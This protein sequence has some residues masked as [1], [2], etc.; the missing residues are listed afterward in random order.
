MHGI[1]LFLSDFLYEKGYDFLKK[2]LNI[3][4]PCWLVYLFCSFSLSFIYI[5]C[6]LLAA[7]SKPEAQASANAPPSQPETSA[8]AGTTAATS[9][10]NLEPPAPPS[11]ILEALQQRLEKYESAATQA[12]E[13]G[14]GSKARRMGRIVKVRIE[15]TQFVK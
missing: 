1:S 5:C 4:V 3:T 2:E 7:A 9:K 8:A 10:A 12:K 13:E 6:Y 11:S 14:N 15:L